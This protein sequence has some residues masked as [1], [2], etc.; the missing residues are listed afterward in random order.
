[1][2]EGATRE[3]AWLEGKTQQPSGVYR[4]EVT[5]LLRPGRLIS[6]FMPSGGDRRPLGM[7]VAQELNGW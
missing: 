3:T 2:P 5:A 7:A 1:M 6:K 4:P